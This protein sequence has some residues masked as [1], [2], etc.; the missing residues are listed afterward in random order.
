MNEKEITYED[1]LKQKKDNLES[2]TPIKCPSS[3]AYLNSDMGVL[4]YRNA[5]MDAWITGFEKGVRESLPDMLKALRRMYVKQLM[6][7]GISINEAIEMLEI[8]EE[9]KPEII[10]FFK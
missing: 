7:N 1:Y 3:E 10:T 5:K 4:D 9:S 6:A 8:P 2:E